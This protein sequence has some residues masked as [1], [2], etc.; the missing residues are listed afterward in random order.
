MLKEQS[1]LVVAASVWGKGS[2]VILEHAKLVV[3]SGT[4][5]SCP[6]GRVIVERRPDTWQS[7]R[8]WHR[9]VIIR[10]ESKLRYEA[11]AYRFDSADV[12]QEVL[13]CGGVLWSHARELLAFFDPNT[14]R[15]RDAD[16]QQW[17]AIHIVGNSTVPTEPSP[18]IVE[19]FAEPVEESPSTVASLETRPSTV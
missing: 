10:G 15:W 3:L 14:E 19:P 9:K 18:P 13:L 2:S 7:A 5:L 8:G 4:K 6:E 17:S 1:D 12:Y 16:N 11:P